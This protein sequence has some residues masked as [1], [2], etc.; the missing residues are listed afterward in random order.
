[1]ESPNGLAQFARV[2]GEGVIENVFEKVK[3]HR[4]DATFNDNG[5]TNLELDY[6][7]II[8]QLSNGRFV[9]LWTSE[10]GGADLMEKV[11]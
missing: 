3:E 5:T 1:M 7:D 9:Q 2:F 6:T 11:E 8:V 10:W 4:P